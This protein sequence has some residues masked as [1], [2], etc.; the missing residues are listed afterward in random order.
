MPQPMLSEV[1]I[2][3]ALSNLSIAYKNPTQNYIVD[4]VFPMVTV[5]KQSDYYYT[6][7]KDVWFRDYV[8]Q[9]APGSAFPK[10]A[11]KLSNTQYAAEVFHLGYDIPSELEANQDPAVD[12]R[13]AGAEW[14]ADQFMLHREA[15]FV[16]DFFTT[17][18]WGTSRTLITAE[19]W[20][21]YSNTES[22]PIEHVM[23]GKETVQLATGIEPNTGVIGQQ[24]FNRVRRH[25]QLLDIFKHTERGILNVDQVREAFELE[26]LLVGK[27]THNTANEGGTFS[28]A[29]NWGKNMLL[30]YTPP[31]PGLMV[32]SAGYTFV[33]PVD[34]GGLNI[35]IATVNVPT[36]RKDE[37]QGRHAFDQK[38]VGTDLGYFLASV[39]S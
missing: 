6:W 2:S 1:H 25:P 9:R 35:E 16:T 8:Q 37:L 31:N 28:G 14:I 18:V 22:N 39:T 29:F 38:A 33:W 5:E 12:L 3:A 30:C 15:K 32:P 13:R 10:G 36:M 26:R 24:A 23:I 7:D 27:T 34:N 20:D 17:G 4:E 11:L 19:Q 21:N